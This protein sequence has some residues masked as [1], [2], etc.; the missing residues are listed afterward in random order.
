[1]GK[2]MDT[3][4]DIVDLIR[5]KDTFAHHLSIKIIEAAGGRSHVT[6]PLN[7]RTANALGNV[8]GGAIF[9]IADV[10]FAAASNSEG[11]LSVAI[12]ANMHYM[13]PLTSE[14]RLDAKAEKIKETRR[15]GFY[16]IEIFPPDG[17]FIAVCQAVAY[18]KG[19][20]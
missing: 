2:T 3:K 8:H 4:T 10:A 18:R 6:M 14:G 16:R 17:D 11:I 5:K 19:S 9:A 7:E 20:N 13:A 12:E 1:M 15:L